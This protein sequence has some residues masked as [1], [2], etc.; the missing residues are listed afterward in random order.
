MSLFLNFSCGFSE[1]E[2]RREPPSS[3]AAQD[4]E[5]STQG[6]AAFAQ[7]EP[8]VEQEPVADGA[9]TTPSPSAEE[10]PPVGAVAEPPQAALEAPAVNTAATTPSQSR[11]ESSTQGEAAFVKAESQAEQEPAVDG[12][13][14][15]PS[16]SRAKPPPV[17]AVAEPPQ[18]ALEAPAT[19]TAAT[20]P[21]PSA[22]EPSE[23]SEQP[24]SPPRSSDETPT[25]QMSHEEFSAFFMQAPSFLKTAVQNAL[26]KPV[27]QVTQNDLA[28]VVKLK[29]NFK[30][31]DEQNWNGA[32]KS[33]IPFFSS[34]KELDLSGNRILYE[35]PQFV[36]YMDTLERLDISN[37]GIQD[38]PP[39]CAPQR[40]YPET[41]LVSPPSHECHQ[42]TCRLQ[43]L[44]ELMAQD[45]KYFNDE[46]PL[47]IFDLQNLKVLN[48]SNSSI[49]YI[50]EYI[51]RLTSL[52]EFYMGN[53]NLTLIPLML[54]SLP[55]LMVVDFRSNRFQDEDVRVFQSCK[56]QSV[57]DKEDCR[58]DLRD[59]LDC[60]FY[61]ELDFDRGEPLRRLYTDLS[62]Q[63]LY[64]FES[65]SAIPLPDNDRCY[66]A[67]VGW[68]IDYEKD[69]LLLNKTI[70][71]K[72]VRELRYLID[73][74]SENT[75]FW[76]S[77]Q[78]SD[79]F[80]DIGYE[81]KKRAAFP[82]EVV[83]ERYRLPGLAT[84]I[85]A[86]VKQ[87]GSGEDWWVPHCPHLPGLKENID[88]LRVETDR[89][90]AERE[91]SDPSWL[92]IIF[93]IFKPDPRKGREE[94]ASGSKSL[95]SR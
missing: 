21:S 86:F 87:L 5:P 70:R 53:N 20:T 31:G 66:L 27:Q 8:Q 14:T 44:K 48:V 32:V 3:S 73:Y 93:D 40:C 34:L 7:D 37:T 81:P 28:S 82:Y 75:S 18:A 83:P 95:E 4:S 17:G 12:A 47:S 77:S 39:I 62:G 63:N 91:A 92:Q 41:V 79:W 58:E 29:L 68:M 19:N 42:A 43:N 76:C 94:D 55:H 67:W 13:V 78:M 22:E 56:G 60:D 71:G 46:I 84:R 52:E 64:E 88:R 45:N 16:P 69:P 72:T 35:L 1:K 49:R 36:L 23:S 50:D 30:Y 6:E 15:T 89:L 61:H 2:E 85:N 57:E 51:G 59:S 38:F 65:M 74:Q 10:P 90:Q 54:S 33:Y 26:K 80:F 24:S 9:A 11:A 25:E